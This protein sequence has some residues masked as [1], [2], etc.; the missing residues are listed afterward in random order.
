MHPYMGEAHGAC[1]APAV[2]CLKPNYSFF[3][4]KMMGYLILNL[5]WGG[6]RPKQLTVVNCLQLLIF[7]N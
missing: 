2:L 4:V 1:L 6:I 5:F 3:R 7:N